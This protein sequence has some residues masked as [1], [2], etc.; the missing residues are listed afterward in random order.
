MK[1][2]FSFY[3]SDKSHF[4]KKE[5]HIEQIKIL[6]KSNELVVSL[7]D[8]DQT[9]YDDLRWINKSNSIKA[10]DNYTCQLCHAF[11]SMQGGPVFIQQ[12]KYKTF[13]LYTRNINSCYVIH[14]DDYNFD[15]NFEFYDGFHL[16]KEIVDK[17]ILDG[18]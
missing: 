17:L 3:K 18:I 13:H 4:E 7:Y 6:D 8:E 15:I 10:R 1:K 16:R 12:G 5:E 11:N 9:G 2:I 14:V